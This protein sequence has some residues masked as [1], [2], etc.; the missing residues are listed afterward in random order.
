MKKSRNTDEQIVFA[1][2]QAETG[3]AGRSCSALGVERLSVR[4]ISHTPDQMLLV[5][6]IRDLAATRTRLTAISRSI[7]CCGGKGGS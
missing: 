3:T 2:K 5:M 7:S 4:Y 6:R 1:L